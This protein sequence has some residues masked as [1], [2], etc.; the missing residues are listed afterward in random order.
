MTRQPL[1]GSIAVVTGASSGVGAAAARHLAAA[2]ASVF[3][4]GR[5]ADKTHTVADQVGGKA[6]CADFTRFSDVRRLA[7]ELLSRVPQIDILANNAGLVSARRRLTPDGHEM[8]IQVNFLSPFLL[9]ALLRESLLKAPAARIINT[10]SSLYRYGKLDPEDLDGDRV[11]Y[12]RMRAYNAA[13][14]AGLVHAVELNRRIP[15]TM[16]ATAFHPGSVR[17]GLDRDAPI[18][19]ALKNSA[20]GRLATRSPDQGAEPLVKLATADQADLRGVYYNKL[21][22]ERLRHPAAT[23]PAFG[24]LLWQRTT[25]I[26]DAPAWHRQ[27]D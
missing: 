20:L 25:D 10:S 1:I 14:L 2:G 7:D 24:A 26:T 11:R 17:S 27:P 15:T 16:A 22:P 13:K 19:S 6:L 5:S 21:K 3:V 9:T 4:V 12:G 8:T 18:V 23:D